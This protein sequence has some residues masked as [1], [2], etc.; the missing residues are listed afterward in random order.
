MSEVGTLSSISLDPDFYEELQYWW[1]QNQMQRPQRA[2]LRQIRLLPL[3]MD[4]PLYAFAM[5]F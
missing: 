3:R 2:L 5:H 4:P 1:K